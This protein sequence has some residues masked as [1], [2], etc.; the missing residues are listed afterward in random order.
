MTPDLRGEIAVSGWCMMLIQEH[1]SS[2][3]ANR[4]SVLQTLRVM[5]QSWRGW[6][7][8]CY[9]SPWHR[10]R[11]PHP[12]LIQGVPIKKGKLLFFCWIC[13][14]FNTKIFLEL[15]L[16]LFIQLNLKFQTIKTK[17]KYL[18]ALWKSLAEIKM[19]IKNAIIFSKKP[20]HSAYFI[21]CYICKINF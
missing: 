17:F 14:F 2:Q 19:N 11:P 12:L 18:E 7:I 9:V 8:L 15:N 3:A 5:L 13:L 6:W 16:L 21:L 20:A 10:P 1:L 4:R